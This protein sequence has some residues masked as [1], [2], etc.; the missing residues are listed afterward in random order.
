MTKSETPNSDHVEIN[1]GRYSEFVTKIFY[2]ISLYVCFVFSGI[3][4]EKLYKTN[5]I[6]GTEKVK[7]HHPSLAIMANSIIASFIANIV[8]MT[9]KTQKDS[10]F[11]KGDKLMLGSYFVLSKL[12]AENSINYLD[13]ISKIIGKSC[14]SVASIFLS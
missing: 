5:Y 4:E 3:F 9:M 6:I 7:F 1:T 11:K 10:P 2:I 8:L 13:F 12:T 14:K